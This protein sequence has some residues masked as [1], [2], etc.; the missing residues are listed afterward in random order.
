MEIVRASETGCRWQ[1]NDPLAIK[2]EVPMKQTTHSIFF[3][4]LSSRNNGN[5]EFSVSLIVHCLLPHCVKGN[6]KRLES[7]ESTLLLTCY[8][9]IE[10]LW[11]VCRGKLEVYKCDIVIFIFKLLSIY[12]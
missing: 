6:M 5:T 8:Y 12:L 1:L 10:V 4:H 11:K 2:S 9:E 7:V 3:W